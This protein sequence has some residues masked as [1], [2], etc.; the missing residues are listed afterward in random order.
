MPN[1]RSLDRCRVLLIEDES[2]IRNLIVALLNKI[3][4]TEID[5][6]PSGEYAWDMLVGKNARPYDVVIVDLELP[7]IS[8]RGFLKQLRELPHPRAQSI[9]VIVLTGVNEPE[10]YKKLE[11]FGIS[12]YLIKPV[13]PSVL[14]AA[15]EK[16][17]SG[18]IASARPV[19]TAPKLD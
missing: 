8:G 14:Q 17:L 10:M 18:R 11:R 5:D 7:G 3:N 19:S 12:A 1:A 4:V 2:A 13:S 9:P 15:L 6:C 16:A